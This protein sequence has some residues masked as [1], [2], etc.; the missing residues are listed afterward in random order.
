MNLAQLIDPAWAPAGY[1]E[2]WPRNRSSE[3][4]APRVR[5]RYDMP[6]Q[7]PARK[8]PTLRKR[9]KHGL[10]Y[11]VRRLLAE[12]PMTILE[13]RKALPQF[14]VFQIS[15]GVGVMTSTGQVWHEG[16]RGAYRYKLTTAGRRR[17]HKDAA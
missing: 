4:C 9:A 14:D 15:S 10:V 3:P 16:T 11:S 13:L 8:P 17:A 6:P 5:T 2:R 1:P 12:R 7:G